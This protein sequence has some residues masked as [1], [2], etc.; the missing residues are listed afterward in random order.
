MVRVSYEG[1]PARGVG[2]RAHLEGTV[3][4]LYFISRAPSGD[5]GAGQRGVVEVDRDRVVQHTVQTGWPP[6]PSRWRRNSRRAMRLSGLYAPRGR[7]AHPRT[8]LAIVIGDGVAKSVFDEEAP[9]GHSLGSNTSLAR[10][11]VAYDFRQAL[12]RQRQVHQVG[13]SGVD[14]LMS[15]LCT[16]RRRHDVIAGFHG[17]SSCAQP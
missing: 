12:G 4:A 1:C 16:T 5:K 7:R 15:K 10:I 9:V 17:M 14:Q 13:C 8:I 3:G 2:V 6:S 11:R